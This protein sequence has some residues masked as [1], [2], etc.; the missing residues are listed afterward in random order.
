MIERA[1]AWQDQFKAF[2]IRYETKA[3][4]W[5]NLLIVSFIIIFIRLIIK[6]TNPKQLQYGLIFLKFV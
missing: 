2:I 4:A 1:K 5:I 3:K 6:K